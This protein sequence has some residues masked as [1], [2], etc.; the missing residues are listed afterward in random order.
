MLGLRPSISKRSSNC[1]TLWKSFCLP[2]KIILLF[3][4]RKLAPLADDGA[5]APP[6]GAL[7]VPE[8]EEEGPSR[9]P[10][11][12]DDDDDDDDNDARLPLAAASGLPL[13][14]PPPIDISFSFVDDVL[15]CCHVIIL[16]APPGDGDGAELCEGPRNLHRSNVDPNGCCIV[17]QDR[18]TGIDYNDYKVEQHN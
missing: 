15:A 9:Y 6:P 13:V 18:K 16:Q 11:F 8:E 3:S 7:I 4:S 1:R 5:A 17:R 2:Q 12:D 10:P 14:V